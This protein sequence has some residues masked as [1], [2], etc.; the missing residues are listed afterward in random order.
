MNEYEEV[1]EDIF[2]EIK[3]KKQR[4][5]TEP[6]IPL[7]DEIM[8]NYGQTTFGEPKRKYKIPPLEDEFDNIENF[9]DLHDIIGE[10]QKARRRRKKRN[11]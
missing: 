5:I 7:A 11:F 3:K 10:T 1:A 8:G 4:K 6:E 2:G 9:E